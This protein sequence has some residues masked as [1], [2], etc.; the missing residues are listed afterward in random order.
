MNTPFQRICTAWPGLV[1]ARE[2]GMPVT[3]F[4]ATIIQDPTGTRSHG[5]I[6][7]PLRFVQMDRRDGREGCLRGGGE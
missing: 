2:P 3:S 7:F 5:V 4:G 6:S 1:I